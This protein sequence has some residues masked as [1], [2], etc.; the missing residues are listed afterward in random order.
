MTRPIYEPTT[1]RSVR[2][3]GFSSDQLFRR[4]NQ[5]NASF[6]GAWCRLGLENDIVVTGPGPDT[7]PFDVVANNFPDVFDT[8][9]T[10]PGPSFAIQALVD[11]VYAVTFGMYVDVFTPVVTDSPIVWIGFQNTTWTIEEEYFGFP[12]EDFGDYPMGSNILTGTKVFRSGPGYN[13]V[14]MQ[15]VLKNGSTPI[16]FVGV[17]LNIT[18]MEMILLAECDPDFQ[19]NPNDFIT[20]T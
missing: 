20:I 9:N 13:P 3:L 10:A 16:G 1:Q 8:P 18:Y 15:I 11:G 19:G 6:A 14:F 12:F 7:P 5:N 2:R 17:D 4:P